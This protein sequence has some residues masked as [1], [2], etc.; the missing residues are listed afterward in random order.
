MEKSWEEAKGLEQYIPFSGFNKVLPLEG[1][2][3]LRGSTD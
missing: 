1:T 3:L 2:S